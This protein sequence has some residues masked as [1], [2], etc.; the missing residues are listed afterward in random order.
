MKLDPITQ[1][2]LKQLKEE[3]DM[4]DTHDPLNHPVAKFVKR[5]LKAKAEK[6]ILIGGIKN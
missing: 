1:S 4:G 3:D 2:L 5:I 6:P